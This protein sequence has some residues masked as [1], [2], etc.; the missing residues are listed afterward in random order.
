MPESSQRQPAVFIGHGS[1]TNALEVNRH[2]RAWSALGRGLAKPKAVLVVS[3]HWYVAG[4][5]VTAMARPKTIHDFYGF[6]PELHTYEYPAPGE[7]VLAERVRAVLSGV[8]VEL[9][10]GWGLDHGAWSVLAHMYPQADVPVIQLSIDATKPASFHLQVGRKLAPLRDEGVLILGSG[11]VVHNLR[12]MRRMD[13]AP[14]FD[15]AVQFNDTLRERV[16]ARDSQ[17]L[18]D[19]MQFGEAARLS[20]PTPEHYL[21]LLYVTGAARDDDRVEVLTDGIELGAISMLSVR[22]G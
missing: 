17:A 12:V 16:L 6:A 11:N 10:E 14:P 22:F 9:D 7:P 3:A 2:T 4:T 13:E 20:I 21:P 8:D 19:L 15:W 5:A 1:P 18:A